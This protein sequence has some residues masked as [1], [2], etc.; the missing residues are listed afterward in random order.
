MK[1]SPSVLLVLSGLCFSISSAQIEFVGYMTSA[2]GPRF[3]L[4]ESK[5]EKA[6][7]WLLLGDSHSG[8]KLVAHD[9]Q[10]GILSVEKN[11]DRFELPLKQERVADGNKSKST[12]PKIGK[13]TI[14]FAGDKRVPEQV[15]RDNMQIRS[16]DEFNDVVIDNA[17]RS[18]YRTG[19]FKQIEF[20]HE[21]PTEDTLNVVVIVTPN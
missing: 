16:G 5:E 7:G 9:P 15:V 3:T 12:K 18:L 13:V 20:K 17:I 4:K 19:R 10:R 6:S 14:Q 1:A 2:E 8:F 21:Q 11:G